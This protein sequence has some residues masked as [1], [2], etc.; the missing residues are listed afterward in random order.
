MMD[1]TRLEIKLNRM[2]QKDKD[3][4]VRLRAVGLTIEQI[5][6]RTGYSYKLVIALLK[7]LNLYARKPKGYR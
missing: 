5:M 2:P 7:S 6:G 4:I 3:R 1:N